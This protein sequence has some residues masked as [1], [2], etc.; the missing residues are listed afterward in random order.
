MLKVGITLKDNP[1]VLII[2][3]AIRVTIRDRF[4]T[5]KDVAG[6]LLSVNIDSIIAISEE[7]M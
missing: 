3:D 1:E 5:I 6:K 4:I 7:N 2:N